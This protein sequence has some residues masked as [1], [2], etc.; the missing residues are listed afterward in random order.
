MKKSVI[1]VALNFATFPIDQ[2]NSF[3]ILLLVCLK[4]NPLFPDL[5]VKYADLQV[6]V[7]TFQTSLAASRVG[8]PKD[9]AALSEATDAVIVALRQIAGYIQSLGLTKESDVLSSGFD[10]IIPGR[11]PQTPLPQPEFTLDNS[12]PGQLGINLTAVPNAKSYHVQYATGSGAMI[13]LG[14]FP[15]TRNILIPS[16]VAGTVYS[17][18][19][20]AIGGSTNYSPWS[21]VMSLMST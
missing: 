14:I 13:D 20:Q 8:G 18:R 1:R 17:A 4:N 19:I 11:S 10:I 15:N 9:T 6:L 16:T 7:T 12:V 3:L 2:L 5:P 21:T